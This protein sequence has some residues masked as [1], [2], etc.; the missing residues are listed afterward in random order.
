MSIWLV[1]REFP[2]R[3][4]VPATQNDCVRGRLDGKHGYTD[5]LLYFERFLMI[6]RKQYGLA[7]ECCQE[8]NGQICSRTSMEKEQTTQDSL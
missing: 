8:I 3:D 7:S 5:G 6:N 4:L 1:C 2:H